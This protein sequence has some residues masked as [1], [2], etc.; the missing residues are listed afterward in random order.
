MR[1]EDFEIKDGV[2]I[3]YH[4]SDTDVVIPDTLT[5]IGNN[6][7]ECCTNL[8][9]I[10]IPDNVTKIGDNAFANCANLKYVRVPEHF[11]I[12]DLKEHVFLSGP[13]VNIHH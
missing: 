6:A 1:T 12:D 11:D 8:K 5:E 9:S 7:F 4:G 10:T 3:K 13:N 2:L